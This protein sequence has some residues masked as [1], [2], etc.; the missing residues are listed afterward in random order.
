MA[1]EHLRPGNQISKV[2]DEKFCVQWQGHTI[3]TPD[4]K[5]RY[6][7]TERE[8]KAFLDQCDATGRIVG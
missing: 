1:R 3:Y 6:F 4:G 2:A 8:A 7:D 5:L